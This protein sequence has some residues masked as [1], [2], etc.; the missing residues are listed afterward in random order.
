[1]LA[2]ENR[3]VENDWN[4]GHALSLFVVGMLSLFSILCSSSISI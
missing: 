3:V 4:I 1:M 2:N